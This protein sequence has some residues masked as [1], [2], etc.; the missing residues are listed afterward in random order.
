MD[1]G[2]LV[3][4]KLWLKSPLGIAA[5]TPS[6]PA[7]AR[8]FARHVDPSSTAPVL[9][10]GGGTGS[11]TRAILATGLPADRLV[12]VEREPDLA[13]VLRHRFPGVQ[14]VEGDA[15]SLDALL[16]HYGVDRISIT[17]SSLPIIWF[18]LPV[19]RA[20]IDAAFVRMGPDGRFLQITNQFGSPL[21]KRRLG[22]TGRRIDYVWA[23]LPPSSAWEFRRTG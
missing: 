15:G 7:V 23:N 11:I 5:L 16:G 12:V 4:F 18:P 13:R 14:V 3:F 8:A 6:S 19:Q 10:L 1:K 21:P 22:L 20:V 17:V 9:E 2:A